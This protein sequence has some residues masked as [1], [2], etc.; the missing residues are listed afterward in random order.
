LEDFETL[1]PL[2]FFESFQDTSE[3]IIDMSFHQQPW[4]S[5]ICAK[6]HLREQHLREVGLR[7]REKDGSIGNLS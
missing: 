7:E 2:L 4:L 5:D 6:Q 1:S 3:K